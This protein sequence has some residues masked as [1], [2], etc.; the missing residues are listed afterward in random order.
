MA[1][2]AD[3]VMADIALVLVLGAVFAGL[4]RKLSQPAVIAEITAGIAL[5]P[6][7][8]GLFPGDLPGRL[9]PIQGRPLLSGVAEIGI[10][11]FM[12]LVGWQ[13]EIELVRTRRCVVTAIALSSML[14]PFVGGALLAS[15]LYPGHATVAGHHVNRTAFI[16]FVGA[17]LAITAF[18]VLARLIH[19]HNLHVTSIGA[20]TL[21]SAAVCD[22]LAWCMLAAV[23]AVA[24][25][26]GPVALVEML[27]Y[28]AVFCLILVGV[29]KPALLHLLTSSAIAERDASYVTTL[30]AAG[31]FLTA[32]CA[33]R[34]GFDAIFGAFAFGLAMPR[35]AVLTAGTELRR[36]LEPTAELL[37]PIFFIVTGLS[38]NIRSL[39][40]GGMLTLLA[41]LCVACSSKIL[42][43][44]VP[45]R[46]AGIG[47]RDS[48]TLGLLMNTRG[49]TE[50]IVLSV[51][52]SLGI[53]DTRMFTVMVLM[54]LITT[55]I[56]GPL[57]PRIAVHGDSLKVELGS[58]A[59]PR[60]G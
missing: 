43:A 26:S 23:A 17:A 32:Y 56:A 59:T 33:T 22:A 35:E 38:V 9:F 39:G 31:V 8:L 2:S 4:F 15:I 21:A 1:G 16:L 45:A 37:M 14:I 55:A 24:R 50:L 36:R 60:S 11:L 28:S 46:I 41:V 30:V 51:G 34:I 29:V 18:P 57:L 52:V 44:A 54:A 42:G 5:G 48:A 19:E 40:L 6:S 58:F 12:F 10:L 53:L 3:M 49:L 20:L 47:W 25:S 7:L 13:L 27:F